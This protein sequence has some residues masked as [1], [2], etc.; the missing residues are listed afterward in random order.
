MVTE[1][2][3]NTCNF[4]SVVAQANGDDPIGSAPTVDH[5]IL[6]E[7]PQ[8]W[9]P[10]W[11]QD[12]PVVQPILTCLRGLL[13]QSLKIK[14]VAI[15]PDKEYSTPDHTRVIYYRRPAQRFTTYKK[16]D[17]VVPDAETTAL[18]STILAYVPNASYYRSTTQCSTHALLLQE[19]V[20][21]SEAFALG[22]YESYRHDTT[23]I[24]DILVC[25]HGN[26]DAACARFGFPI[27]KA[28]RQRSTEQGSHSQ[29][30]R[31]WRCS[32]FGGHQY[33]PTLL[34]FPD[35]RCWGHLTMEALDAI[36]EQ[37]G[38]PAEVYPHYRGWAGLEK[39]EQ[40]AEREIW[41]REGWQW[42]AA[43]KA[44]R[45][46]KRQASLVQRI[47]WPILE[48]IPIFLVKRWVKRSQQDA[49]WTKV[50]I[51]FDGVR[52]GKAWDET[53]YDAT[54]AIADQVMTAI[55]SQPTKGQPPSQEMPLVPINRYC[56]R[57]LSNGG[58]S[59]SSQP[60]VSSGLLFDRNS[61]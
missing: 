11:L 7:R 60:G 12:D 19:E 21:A 9:A 38:N 5:W 26:V 20:N 13:R 15:A 4:C 28:L 16:Y 39:F 40:I 42:F 24:R 23:H 25:T 58:P 33:A 2:N 56:V 52:H 57:E 55:H 1:N 59:G 49:Q 51:E 50:R 44:G 48:R 10:N 3:T 17:Y 53:Y 54:V 6:I 30:L 22:R 45:I 37:T 27:Y 36:V 34:D 35:G 43:P 18:L 31:A 29:R 8:P 32:H 41:L 14:L 46:L 47:L 61:R